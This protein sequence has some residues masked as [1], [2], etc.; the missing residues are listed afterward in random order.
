MDKERKASVIY[1][2]NGAQQ[3]FSFP[4]DYLRKAFVKAE[5]IEGS[6]IIELEQGRDY[7][8]TDKELTLNSGVSVATG[9]RLKIY[10]KTTTDP[11]VEWQDASVLLANDLTVKDT[12][13]LHLIEEAI[14]TSN[15]ALDTTS[16]SLTN[17]IKKVIN[18]TSD[19]TG[20]VSFNCVNDLLINGPLG[21]HFG[22]KVKLNGYF[23]KG[24]GG[25]GTYEC[26][27]ISSFDSCLWAIDLGETQ[28]TEYEVKIKDDGTPLKDA[29]GNYVLETDDSGKPIPLYEKDGT[30][31][32]K[33]HMYAVLTETVVNY[34]QFGAKLDG[35]TDDYEAL[36][37]CHEYQRNH[38]TLEPLTGRKYFYVKVENHEGIIHKENNIAIECCGNIDLSGS[39][40]LIQ[41][42]NTGWDGFYIWGDNEKDYMSF[43]RAKSAKDS[44]K[45][46]SFV[47]DDTGYLSTLS[48]NSVLFLKETPYSVRQDDTLYTV[49]RYELLVNIINGLLSTPILYDWTH[50]KGNVLKTKITSADGTEEREKIRNSNFECSFTKI[51]SSHYT[52]TG[53]NVQFEISPNSYNTI[54]WCKCHNAHIKGFRLYADA[55][56]MHNIAY[57]NAMFYIFGCYNVEISDIIGAN[58]AGKQENGIN[59]TSGYVIRAG[60]CVEL[61]LHDISLQGYWGATAMNSVKNVHFTRVNTN[62]IDIHN[63]F[64]NLYIDK[65]N[66]FN[67]GIQIGEGRGI[68]QITNS[69]FYF[70]PLKDDSYPDAHLLELN[71]TYGRIFEGNI[72]IKNCIANVRSPE[73]KKFSVCKADFSPDSS[74]LL[75][76]FKFPEITIKDCHFF[77]YDD[78]TELSYI[79]ISGTRRNTTALSS[80]KGKIGYCFDLGNDSK[81]TLC[82]QYIG[83]GIDWNEGAYSKEID[84]TK[85]QVIRTFKSFKNS[86][87][88]VCFY[89][90]HYFSVTGPGTLPIPTKEN[91]PTDYSGEEF[92]VG[93]AT[94]RHIASRKW[95]GNTK[96]KAGDYCFTEHSHFFPVDCFKCIIAGTSNGYRPSHIEG[97]VLEGDDNTVD[98]QDM[99]YWK[100]ISDA[101]AFITKD[102]S[103]NINV[104]KGDIIYA[105]NRLYKVLSEGVLRSIP[106]LNTEWLGSFK[107]GTAIL[108]F[109]GRDWI[110]SAWWCEN[111]YCVSLGAN[112]NLQIY[113]LVNHD[114]ISSGTPPVEGSGYISDDAILWKQTSKNS[115]KAWKAQTHFNK[116]DIISIDD[117]NYEC[118]CDGDLEMPNQITLENISTNMNKG[119]LFSV[120]ENANIP[121]KLGEKAK[122]TVKIDNVETIDITA[123]SNGYFGRSDNP[124]PTIIDK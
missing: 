47:V 105:E 18:V 66:I 71:T 103:P 37:K 95:Q 73:G 43:E 27:Y 21:L 58:T 61:N 50:P 114:G 67:H 110:P 78:D 24:D 94:L 55:S 77:S 85:G 108:S 70:N 90:I 48:P 109:I 100:H 23:S 35:V 2:G 81:G 104:E 102:F 40:L 111:S 92:D 5:I 75:D 13:L 68:V 113:Q 20:L 54:L 89:D 79:S 80:P 30:T 86:D 22:D 122:W 96:Y 14:D 34:R 97:T 39:T 91:T 112:G 11:L 65:C 4:F 19:R 28:E 115:T 26:K 38:Y 98:T 83:K 76:T 45:K 42:K 15:N 33:K 12:Q 57:Q 46:D 63:Y 29:N 3:T 36:M 49:P 124:T 93:S 84:V 17:I 56:K 9:E 10:R 16:S 25:G 6:N 7:S 99:C 120:N 87:N 62:R 72:F 116:G 119:A 74:S 123:P 82:W 31:V 53:C 117:T 69:N 107:E 88:K 51:P 106:P 44:W 32:R 8:I 59:A 1:E 52:F 60:A 64:Y 41:D 101:N 121:T 118:I